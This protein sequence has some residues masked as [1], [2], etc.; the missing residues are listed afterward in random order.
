MTSLYLYLISTYYLISISNISISF[1]LHI[2]ISI[3]L[4]H[5]SCISLTST[6]KL[7][8]LHSKSDRR[9]KIPWRGRP[10][11]RVNIEVSPEKVVKLCWKHGQLL[12]SCLK[13]ELMWA[14]LDKIWKVSQP[15]ASS[16]PRSTWFYWSRKW[17][18]PWNIGTLEH[19]GTIFR[20][21]LSR[22][23]F[24]HCIH[25]SFAEDMQNN[26]EIN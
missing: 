18:K 6:A 19:V 15:L 24:G 9:A 25:Q 1:Y 11:V 4:L 23:W 13:M 5:N 3:S 16:S 17:M 20:A 12:R 7:L 22:W 2:Y 10:Q 21:A 8:D 14:N 26:R